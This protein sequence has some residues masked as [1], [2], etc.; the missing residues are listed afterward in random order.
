MET[1]SSF[2]ARRRLCLQ[3]LLAGAAPA[4]AAL[5]ASERLLPTSQSLQ[6]DLALAQAGKQP[7][8]VM[9][10]L[11]GCPF[12]KLVRE[13]YLLPLQQSGAVVTQI[14][15][16][17]PEPLRDWNG[18]AT[19]HGGMVWQLEIEVAPTVLFYGAGRREVADRL[20]GSSIPDFYGAYLDGRMKIARAAVQGR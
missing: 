11:H 16:L 15:F 14:H 13:H 6:H 19:T 8:V 18:V 12:C 4:W 17:S 1:A 2:R 7:L 10:S 20:I 5:D 9:A 3:L